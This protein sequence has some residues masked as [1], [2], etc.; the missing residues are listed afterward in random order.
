MLRNR[1]RR[2]QNLGRNEHPHIIIIYINYKGVWW[3]VP[4]KQSLV[5]VAIN[6]MADT[7]IKINRQINRLE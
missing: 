7:P 2:P 1:S 4:D 5:T 3:P 6:K